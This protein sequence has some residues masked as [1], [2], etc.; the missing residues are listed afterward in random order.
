MPLF[1]AYSEHDA[2]EFTLSL[3]DKVCS[4]EQSLIEILASFKLDIDNTEKSSTDSRSTDALKENTSDSECNSLCTYTAVQS[5]AQFI[6][7]NNS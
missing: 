1:Y 4:E 3:I 6:L 7:Y 5:T 2:H